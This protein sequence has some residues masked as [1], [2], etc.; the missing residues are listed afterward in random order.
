MT[1]FEKNSYFRL[2]VTYCI[3]VPTDI[4]IFKLLA[5]IHE[6]WFKSTPS[7]SSPIQ[8]NPFLPYPLSSYLF[9]CN[10][11]LH[12]SWH[13]WK[14]YSLYFYLFLFYVVFNWHAVCVYEMEESEFLYSSC[15][16]LLILKFE[17]FF[18][19]WHAHNFEL[20]M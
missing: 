7:S 19:D 3:D 1:A 6:K 13:L 8:I 2:I 11:Y 18:C 5:G 15:V 20:V 16:L 14:T 10:Y 9:V 12:D 17:R 4:L